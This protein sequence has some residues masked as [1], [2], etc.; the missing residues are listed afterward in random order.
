MALVLFRVGIYV[1]LA[2]LAAWVLRDGLLKSYASYLTEHILNIAGLVGIGLFVL[3]FLAMIYEKSTS[4]RRRT[5]CKICGKPV[6]AGEYYCR[7]HLREIVD[8]A[9]QS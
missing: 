2:V 7:E 1:L 5:R 9:R 4:G 3:G 8:R 6:I